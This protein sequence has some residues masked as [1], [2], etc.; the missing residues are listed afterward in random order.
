MAGKVA[1]TCAPRVARGST[2]SGWPLAVT[3]GPALGVFR[4]YLK[5]LKYIKYLRYL[6]Y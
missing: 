2:K 1:A 5:Y 3:A 6:P 4:C